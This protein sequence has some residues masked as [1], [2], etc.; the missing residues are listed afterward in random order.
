MW[1]AAPTLAEDESI[2]WQKAANRQQSELRAVGGRL[3]LTTRRLVFQ[4]N[5]FDS[6]TRG[7]AWAIDI[8]DISEVAVQGRE[9][10]TP[11][12]GKAAKLRRRLRIDTADGTGCWWRPAR[13]DAG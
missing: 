6:R 1:V 4:P 8:Q 11:F 3:F 2:V 13:S 12:L 9:T 7:E 5:R 10:T